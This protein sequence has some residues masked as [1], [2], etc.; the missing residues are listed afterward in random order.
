M[1]GAYSTHG[2]EER[3]RVHLEHLGVGERII[4]KW[5]L[6][7]WNGSR[8]WVVWFGIGIVGGLL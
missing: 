6:K 8:D 2:G 7:K 4:L 1:R 3:E 5:V